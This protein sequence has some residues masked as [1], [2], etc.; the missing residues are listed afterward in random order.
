MKNKYIILDR[1]G[2]INVD[3]GYV[4]DI[5][6]INFI[7]GA[8]EG[9]NKLKNAGFRFIIVTNQSGIGRGYFTLK[10]YD[11]FNSV[12]LE[13]LS[14][15]GINIDKVYT[16]PHIE[17][18]NCECR[19][20]KLKMFNEAINDFNV[21]TSNSYVIG[22]KLR[23][24]SISDESDIKGIIVGNTFENRKCFASLKEAAEYIIYEEKK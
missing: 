8:I 23:D 10:D 17:E 12:F 4:H 13:K 5:K 6:K 7:D 20:P 16:C 3:Y 15:F 22:D 2:T 24:I 9:L 19:K 1:D 11:I 21:D 18:D 14:N